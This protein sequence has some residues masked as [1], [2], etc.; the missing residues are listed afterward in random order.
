MPKFFDECEIKRLENKIQTEP[1]K[2]KKI[3]K[4]YDEYKVGVEMMEPLIDELR[5]YC[6]K[7]CIKI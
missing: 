3:S 6:F 1:D 4:K 7:G 5:R 2:M